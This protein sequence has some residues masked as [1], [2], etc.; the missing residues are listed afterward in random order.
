[1]KQEF[2]LHLDPSHPRNSFRTEVRE[3]RLVGVNPDDAS[4]CEWSP[5]RYLKTT[6][7]FPADAIIE[8]NSYKG[9]VGDQTRRLLYTPCFD[10]EASYYRG[11]DYIDRVVLLDLV[12]LLKI[13][14]NRSTLRRLEGIHVQS[15]LVAMG[16]VKYLCEGGEEFLMDLKRV[17]SDTIDVSIKVHMPDPCIMGC[18]YGVEG[19]QGTVVPQTS[20]ELEKNGERPCKKNFGYVL[21]QA[22]KIIVSDNKRVGFKLRLHST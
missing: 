14:A 12:E 21:Y 1:L 13:K 7:A 19:T 20:Y 18:E 17:S 15:R 6:L 10:S 3:D 4:P 11:G 22:S 8:D 5:S 16:L 2:V 9:V